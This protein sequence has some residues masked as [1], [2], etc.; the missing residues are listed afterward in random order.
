MLLLS[1]GANLPGFVHAGADMGYFHVLVYL[2][3]LNYSQ[4]LLSAFMSQ[5][6]FCLVV[7]EYYWCLFNSW[8]CGIFAIFKLSFLSYL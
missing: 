8:E 7:K 3:F 4:L 5:P 6:L 2:L 1:R